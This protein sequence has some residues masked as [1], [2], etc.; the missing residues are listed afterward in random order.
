MQ[1]PCEHLKAH[2]NAL[3]RTAGCEECLQAG[4]TWVQLRRC[5]R[6]GHVGCCD[7]SKNK[8]ASRHY[9][10]TK[11]PVIQSFEAGEYWKWCYADNITVN[12]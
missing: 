9:E 1:K 10:E 3:A 5:L 6:C 7:A 12:T 2:D 4:E 8:H 11:H